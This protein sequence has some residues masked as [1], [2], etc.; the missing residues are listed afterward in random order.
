MTVSAEVDP[1]LHEFWTGQFRAC[2][3]DGAQPE[4]ATDAMLVIALA[5]QA[6]TIG[7]KATAQ[8]L[9]VLAQKFFMESETATAGL[10]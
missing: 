5:L 7:K 9:F 2:L 1:K 4:A 8:M 6:Q 10:H 3:A